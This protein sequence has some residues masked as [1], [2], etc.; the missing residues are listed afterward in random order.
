MSIDSLSI[1][2]S[3]VYLYKHHNNIILISCQIKLMLT[4]IL[5]ILYSVITTKEVK[6]QNYKKQ[7][8]IY[9]DP[10]IYEQLKKIAEKEERSVSYI[11]KKAF[12]YFIENHKD[13][14]E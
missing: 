2:S 8:S 13:K 9:I 1:L 4:Q 12:V 5:L 14:E 11:I 7:I 6:M 3:F 10:I